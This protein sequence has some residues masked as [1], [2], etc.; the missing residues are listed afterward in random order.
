MENI[1]KA[2]IEKSKAMVTN[3]DNRIAE[4]NQLV[5]K[6]VLIEKVNDFISI[7]QLV[8]TGKQETA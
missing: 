7:T 1:L 3:I 8:T 6:N 4:I 2:H 5:G